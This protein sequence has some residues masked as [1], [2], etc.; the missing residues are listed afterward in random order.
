MF[1]FTFLLNTLIYMLA[2]CCLMLAKA[3]FHLFQLDE[4]IIF[5]K[6]KNVSMC[7]NFLNFFV[8]AYTFWEIFWKIF[9]CYKHGNKINLWRLCVSYIFLDCQI[10]ISS[11]SVYIPTSNISEFLENYILPRLVLPDYFC[12][13]DVCEMIFQ[14]GLI[15]TS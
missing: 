7:I 14:F 13:A 3:D 9:L 15:C 2:T 10:T 4:C 6:E 5:N 12:P 11:I 1:Y 8:I